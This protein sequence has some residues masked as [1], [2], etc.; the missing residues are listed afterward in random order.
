MSSVFAANLSA[1]IDTMSPAYRVGTLITGG[2]TLAFWLFL[3]TRTGEPLRRTLRESCLR[4]DFFCC[5]LCGTFL[6]GTFV[7]LLF[8]S[9]MVFLFS[10]FFFLVVLFVMFFIMMVTENDMPFMRVMYFFLLTTLMT[11]IY[12][13]FICLRNGDF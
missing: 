4:P 13:S 5:V 2:I 8:F 3:R 12:M 10:V 7:N 1:L 6:L 9:N 11:A